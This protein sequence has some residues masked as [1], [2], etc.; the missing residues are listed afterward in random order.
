MNDAAP[1]EGG[2]VLDSETLIN[3]EVKDDNGHGRGVL[4]LISPDVAARFMAALGS[5]LES[6]NKEKVAARSDSGYIRS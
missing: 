2:G 5:A 4:E 3:A 1:G 6:I